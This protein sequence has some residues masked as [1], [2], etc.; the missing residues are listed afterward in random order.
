[1]GLL[2]SARQPPASQRP[3]IS[4]Q[5]C[6]GVVLFAVGFALAGCH[7]QPAALVDLLGV[8]PRYVSVGDRIELLG[9]NLPPG[10][11][12]RVL[13]EGTVFR[14]GAAPRSGFFAESEA[15]SQP[16]RAVGNLTAALQQALIGSGIASRHATFR[17]QATLVFEPLDAASPKV[18][19]TLANVV[20]D[21]DGKPL[22]VEEDREQTQEATRFLAH[23]GMAFESPQPPFRV[24]EVKQNGLAH[25]AGVKPGDVLIEIDSVNL[26]SF[27][28]LAPR[29]DQVESELVLRRGNNPT[30]VSLSIP[31][32]AY[33]RQPPSWVAR[34]AIG[35][36][37]FALC[38]MLCCGTRFGQSL[39]WLGAQLAWRMQEILAKRADLR[40]PTRGRSALLAGVLRAVVSVA[41]LVFFTWLS[42]E[43]GDEKA[44]TLV[45]AALGVL[46][47]LV[48]L[49][50]GGRVARGSWSLREA[51]KSGFFSLTHL[52]LA[53]AA[54]GHVALRIGTFDLARVA[55][56]QEALI[57]RWNAFASPLSLAALGLYFVCLVPSYAPQL[58]RLPLAHLRG[59]TRLPSLVDWFFLSVL[60]ALGAV[61]F[62]GGWSSAGIGLGAPNLLSEGLSIALFWS[63]SLLLFSAALL[64]RA[65]VRSA[66]VRDLG[67]WLWKWAVLPGTLLLAL[68]PFVERLSLPIIV[69]D[70]SRV[71]LLLI[72][73]LLSLYLLLQVAR[74]WRARRPELGIQPWV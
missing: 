9:R 72:F 43:G 15:I 11:H 53:F 20:L 32:G 61:F 14:P 71:A 48:A 18:T 8:S 59:E 68:T 64:V 49:I 46:L 7:R 2:P 70:L 63:K 19:G 42:R 35:L 13:L 51:L 38:L 45:Y 67:G 3:P 74:A 36:G 62:L 57:W 33:H 10:K 21:V 39:G 56:G 16:D 6:W 25:Q 52:C 40:V 54:L 23:A 27:T 34:S 31:T 65:A 50:A 22:S 58:T 55:N 1:M 24:S 60:A 69:A 37:A 26:V 47:L 4:L 66:S 12:A 30:P 41:V 17:G 44:S 28:D 29:P 5:R 73:V